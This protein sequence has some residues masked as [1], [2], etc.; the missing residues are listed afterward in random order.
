[1]WEIV[2]RVWDWLVDLFKAKSRLKQVRAEKQSL[3][4]RCDAL[5]ERLQ[6]SQQMLA[7][8]N[9]RLLKFEVT[10]KLDN[11]AVVILQLLSVSPN[12]LT[13]SALVEMGISPTRMSYLITTLYDDAYIAADTLTDDDDVA[14]TIAHRGREYLIKNGLVVDDKAVR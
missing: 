11:E 3:E 5:K 4:K 7:K 14:Y 6:Q 10:T 1:M 12:G 2:L 9:E 8:L 13:D